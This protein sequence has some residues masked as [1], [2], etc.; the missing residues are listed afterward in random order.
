MTTTP[1]PALVA[2]RPAPTDVPIEEAIL[3]T[4]AYADVFDFALREPELQRYL[5]GRVATA[6]EVGGALDAMGDRVVRRDGIVAAAGRAALIEVRQERRHSAARTWPAAL[7]YARAVGSLPFVRMVAIT[8]ALAV[9]NA[10]EGADI[11]LLVVTEP[12]RVW[13]TRAGTIAIVRYAAFEGHDLCPNYFLAEH[14]PVTEVDDL[15]GAHELVQMVPVVGAGVYRRLREANAWTARHLPNA[16]GA[17]LGGRALRPPV[18]RRARPIAEALLRTPVGSA[19]E[20][21]ERRKIGR[22]RTEAAERGVTAEARFS[23]DW[24]KGHLDGHGHRIRLA[25]EARA[26]ALGVEPLW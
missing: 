18:L 9:G 17:P 8:G 25:Y 24:C 6:A 20:G 14:A 19:A 21:W 22:F 7:R 16:A 11:D 26:R 12:G 23:A 3:R 10:T 1:D 4:L 5:I 13:L 2:P 15:Y